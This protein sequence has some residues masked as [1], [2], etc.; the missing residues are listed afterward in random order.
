MHCFYVVSIRLFVAVIGVIIVKK[1]AGWVSIL[2]A[3]FVPGHAH[4]SSLIFIRVP[5]GARSSD[6]FGG[7]MDLRGGTGT[8]ALG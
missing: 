6:S 4:S 1:P 2:G 3:F 8:A 5:I 7:R